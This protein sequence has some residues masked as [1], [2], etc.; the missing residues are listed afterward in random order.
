MRDV[1]AHLLAALAADR[2]SAVLPMLH[3]APGEDGAIRDVLELLGLPYVG[4]RAEPCRLSFDKPVAKAVLA[5]TGALTPPAV[6]LPHQ[7]FRE[8]GASARAGRRRRPARAAAGG[9]ARA[10]RVRARGDGGPRAP[11]SCPRR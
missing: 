1:D 5:R 2:P 10:R 3:G 9:Q 4:S 8:L 6:A 11:P 7:T